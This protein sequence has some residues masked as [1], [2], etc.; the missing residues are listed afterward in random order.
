MRFWALVALW[1]AIVRESAWVIP[2]VI[3][4]HGKVGTILYPL[5]ITIGFAALA[6][7]RG[8]YRWITAMLRI[9]IGIA[10]LGAVCD[11][12]GIF[13]GPGTPGVSWG[14]FKNFIIYTGQVNSFLPMAVIPTLAVM[15]S[16]I[17]GLLGLAM[18]LGA[19]L[20]VTVW[21]ST[22]LLFLLGAAM[23]ISLGLS[24]TF[25]FAVFVLAAGAFLMA[26]LD[27][28]F[29][30]VDLLF[31]RWHRRAVPAGLQSG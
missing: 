2:Q 5:A 24:S 7:T 11:R 4:Q 18:L 13:G 29:L 27:S 17:E 10:F 14:N 12:F 15:E 6:V 1:V 23:T 30:S 20:R 28:S 16:I 22:A 3:H 26:N 25:P 31:R 21:A 8:R 19:G 9:F